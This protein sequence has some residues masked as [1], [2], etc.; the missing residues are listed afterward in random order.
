[1]QWYM[2]SVALCN[3]LR[4]TGHRALCPARVEFLVRGLGHPPLHPQH[5]HLRKHPKMMEANAVNPDGGAF[6]LLQSTPSGQLQG[7]R[8]L[9]AQRTVPR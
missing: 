2:V 5:P 8:M 9:Y 7:H 1:M 3:V 4:S 6:S